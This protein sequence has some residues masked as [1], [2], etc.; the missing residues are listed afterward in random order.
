M[1]AARKFAALAAGWRHKTLEAEVET[2]ARRAVLDWFA[3]T[4][5]GCVLAPAT[6][7]AKALA[8]GRGSGGAQCYVDGVPSTPR[9]AA[10][11]NA[12]AS[13]TVEFDDIF[14]DGGYHPGSPTVAAALAV[15]QDRNL[16]LETFQRA[17]IAGY[18]VGCR[19]SLAVQP[20]HYEYWHTTSTIGTIGAAVAGAMLLDCD[21][22]AIGHAIGLASSFAGGHQQNLQGVGAAKAMH[23]GHAADAGLLAAYAAAAGLTAATGVLDGIKGFAAATSESTGNWAAAFEG[24]G[25]WTPIARVTVKNHGC[26]GHIFPALDG[27][28]TILAERNLQPEQIASISVAGYAAT[29]KMCDR[30]HPVSAQDA[31]FSL[32]YC[33]AAQSHTG[34]VRLGAFTS[35][36][37]ARHDIRTFMSKIRV[38]ADDDLTA[39]YPRRRMAKLVVK[40]LDGEEIFHIQKTRKGD[41]EDPLA[42]SE[43]VSKY[44]ELTAG[45]I[46]EDAASRLMNVILYEDKLPRLI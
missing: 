27:L 16:S 41:P 43:I 3:T 30:P 39:L 13:H 38:M 23:P 19:I 2:A 22:E 8:S 29:A 45:V 4:L 14:R 21:E 33:L 7:L 24:I 28:R 6:V 32:Q 40:L 12:I 17:L 18:E 36:T 42:D 15:A 1:D 9:H 34:V 25:Q 20:S 10:L 46:Q 37:M 26:C 35:E 44:L 5:P 11:L 31:R